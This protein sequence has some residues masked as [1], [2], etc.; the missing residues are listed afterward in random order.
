MA[1][2]RYRS[3]KPWPILSAGF[4]PFFLAAGLWACI[5][6]LLWMAMLRGLVELPT[7]FPPTVWHFHELIFGFVA[8]A[9]GGFLLTAIPNWTGR[10][11]LQG[12]PLGS[13]VVL[14][15]LGRIAVATSLWLGPPIAMAGD[16]AFLVV[17]LAVVGR[18]IAAGRN[19]RNLPVL[20]A[21]ALLIA[22]NT[23]IHLGTL[24]VAFDGAAWEEAGKRLALSVVIMLI[25]LIGGRIIP[26]FT[27]NWLRRRQADRVPAAFTGF[28]RAVLVVSAGVLS[29]WTIAG[30][31]L[32]AGGGLVLAGALHA[33]RLGRWRGGDTLQ[34]PLLWILHV[35]Y[36]WLP[37]G[38]VLLG[39]AAWRPDLAT[40]AIHALTV[41]GMGTMILAVMTRASL[42][43]SKKE[44]VAGRG[45]VL[46][47]LLVLVAA[48][49]RLAAPALDSGYAAALD[50][51][52]G[53]WIAAFVLFVALYAPLYLRR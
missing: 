53:A 21:I 8:A 33:A 46:V 17:F 25:S 29:L 39:A 51:A 20:I 26:S 47:Y 27:A 36:A 11:P 13:L 3:A 1:I 4:R 42:G 24:D 9:I 22:A 32:L 5:A 34:E 18:E 52:A 7:A 6:M 41:G 45:T 43:H 50:L 30:L 31:T 28:D 2:P 38:L 35:G 10:L 12:W 37:A 14:W 40:S 16:L 48:A 49:S 19:W 15:L 23:L 44:L